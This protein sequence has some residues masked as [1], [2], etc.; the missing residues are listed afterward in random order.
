MNKFAIMMMGVAPLCCSDLCAYSYNAVV[1]NVPVK[2]A[3]TLKSSS[4]V[5]RGAS[6]CGC[7]SSE[8][9]PGSS[10]YRQMNRDDNED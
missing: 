6:G 9:T 1:A 2:A 3:K 7:H 4:K 5:S 8:R 10:I